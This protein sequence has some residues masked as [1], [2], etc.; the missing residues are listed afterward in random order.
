MSATAGWSWPALCIKHSLPHYTKSI[1]VSGCFEH[2][3]CS[4]WL[5]K[6]FITYRDNL[7]PAAA[8]AAAAAAVGCSIVKRMH[9]VTCHSDQPSRRALAVQR[10][11][12]EGQL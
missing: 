9:T 4:E 1:I 7:L 11:F 8:Q 5:C 10:R 6:G 2:Y 12:K 3:W